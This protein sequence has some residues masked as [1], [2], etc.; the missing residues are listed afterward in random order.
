LDTKEEEPEPETEMERRG[1]CLRGHPAMLTLRH[2][3]RASLPKTEMDPWRGSGEDDE[4]RR[5]E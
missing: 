3:L 1:L 5:P 2:C 4:S